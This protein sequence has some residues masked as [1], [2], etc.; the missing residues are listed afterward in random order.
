MPNKGPGGPI[1][2]IGPH[3]PFRGGIAH[4]TERLARGLRQEG[5]S[6]L[7]ISFSRLYPRILFPGRSQVEDERTEELQP[8]CIIDSLNPVSWSRTSRHILESNGKIAVFMYWMPFFAPAYVRIAQRLKKKG[9]R[10]IG[11]VHNALPHERHVGDR[12]LTRRFLRKCDSVM[13]LSRSV[14][15]D[16]LSLVPDARV[17]LHPHPVYDQFGE[18]ISQEAA[19]TKLSIEQNGKV[20]LFFGLVR[21]YKGLHVLLHALP[22]VVR[23]FPEALLLVAGE[24]YEDVDIYRKQISK[25]GIGNHVRLVDRYIPSGEVRDYFS[26]ADVV[27]QPYIKATQSGVIQT[28]FQFAIPVIATDVGGLSEAVGDA[29]LIVPADNPG[30][31]GSAIERFFSEDLKSRLQEPAR[32]IRES[33]TWARYAQVLLEEI[34]SVQN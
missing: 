13:V 32:R 21:T 28:A 29:G 22:R 7:A 5:Q 6:V 25:L 27:V 14:Q 2:L 23:K 16:V 9:V 8:E 31:L 3:P 24:F 30:A 10:I 12:Y 17:R 34:H 15:K 18:A 33:S 11:I 1:V 19:R 20:L 4:F 26:A